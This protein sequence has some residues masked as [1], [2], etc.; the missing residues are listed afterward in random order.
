M[1]RLDLQRYS[2]AFKSRS[3]KI[4]NRTRLIDCSSKRRTE[5]SIAP[6][7]RLPSRFVFVVEAN[8]GIEIAQNV[9]VV[10]GLDILSSSH[11]LVVKG[12]KLDICNDCIYG[13]QIKS[14]YYS[15]RS[16]ELTPFEL[17]HSDVCSMPTKPLGGSLHLITFID[18]CSRNCWLYSWIQKDKVEILT[19]LKRF[20]IFTTT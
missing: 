1:Y 2:T 20:H 10:K 17:M 8:A 16:N 5:H 4:V 18:D 7:D 9:R 15:S 19:G 3:W 12:T 14:S 11:Q 13:K 6:L